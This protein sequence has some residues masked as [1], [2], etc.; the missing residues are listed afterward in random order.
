MTTTPLKTSYGNALDEGRALYETPFKSLNLIARAM[1]E[2]IHD[3]INDFM[4]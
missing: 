1:V 2:E 4:L 3:L